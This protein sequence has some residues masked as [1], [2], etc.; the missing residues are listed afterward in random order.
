MQL[1]SV[2]LYGG[3]NYGSL[4]LCLQQSYKPTSSLVGDLGGNYTFQGTD[5][6]IAALDI[7]GI[8]DPTGAADVTATSL[9]ASQGNYFSAA[10]S[11][12]G[13]VPLAG[14][15]IGKSGKHVKTINNV[16]DVAKQNRE[17]LTGLRNG[18]K[19]TTHYY[20]DSKQAN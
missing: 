15:A 17:Q 5:I 18:S 13:V 7:I 16:I 14:N 20:E 19:P 4:W 11:L 10:G 9:E 3:G 1:S 2:Y 12:V 6:L 8:F